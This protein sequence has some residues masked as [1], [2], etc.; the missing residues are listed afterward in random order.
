MSEHLREAQGRRAEEQVD[1]RIAKLEEIVAE[2]QR[3]VASVDQRLGSVKNEITLVQ[4]DQTHLN[5]MLGLQ[6]K[7]LEASMTSVATS[8]K[9]LGENVLNMAGD[10][11]KSPVGKQFSQDITELQTQMAALLLWKNQVGGG[12]FVIQ[13][14]ATT[15]LMS[16]LI[17]L[18]RLAGL[19]R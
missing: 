8:V 4:R 1:F 6:F 9:V 19:I 10:A 3:T 12:W 16:F 2:L 13:I 17:S 18:L 11:T 5:E 14:M 15:G 7:S